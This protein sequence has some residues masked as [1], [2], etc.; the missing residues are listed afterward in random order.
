MMGIRKTTIKV[1]WVRSMKSETEGDMKSEI[2]EKES[3]NTRCIRAVFRSCILS[4]PGLES[5]N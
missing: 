3:W 1:T 4:Y 5:A 2:E